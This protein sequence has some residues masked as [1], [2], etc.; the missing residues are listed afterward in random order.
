MDNPFSPVIR[1]KS[2]EEALAEYE[3]YPYIIENND[4]KLIAPS[5]GIRCNRRII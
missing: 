2:G 4:Q 5:R 1:E 3:K